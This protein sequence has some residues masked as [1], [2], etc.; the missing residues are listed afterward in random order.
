MGV[1][2]LIS[3]FYRQLDPKT[4]RSRFES[5]QI[6]WIPTSFAADIPQVME[7]QRE[8]PDDHFASKFQIRNMK[9]TDFRKKQKLPI[10][11]LSLGE[12]EELVVA[13]SKL[14]PCVVLKIGQ[15]SFADLTKALKQAGKGHLEKEDFAVIPIYSVEKEDGDA[16]FPPLWSPEL[17][18]LC[19]AVLLLSKTRSRRTEQQRCEIG[20]TVLRETGLS[21]VST[22]R[23]CADSGCAN[24]SS[25]HA[26][27]D[28]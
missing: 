8:S 6:V 22:D 26:R 28:V 15:T 16:G 20:P 19:T 11:L 23:C 14:R 24:D 18:L 1:T 9:E 25:L 21:G 17:R 2:Q 4:F 5:G 7:V 10:K 13:R 3:P 27:A 12:T